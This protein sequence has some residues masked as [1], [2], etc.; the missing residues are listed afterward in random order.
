M[1]LD[2]RLG[3]ILVAFVRAKVVQEQSTLESRGFLRVLAVV[4]LSIESLVRVVEQFLESLAAHHPWMLL[5]HMVVDKDLMVSLIEFKLLCQCV[6][7]LREHSI[8][9][10]Q[11]HRSHDLD[12]RLKSVFT[13]LVEQV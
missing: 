7:G 8:D 6:A 13:R 2:V 4:E 5:M 10:G 1:L 9:I 12:S 3:Q 11:I